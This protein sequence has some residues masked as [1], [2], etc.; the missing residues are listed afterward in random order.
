M[1]SKLK[2]IGYRGHAK[3]KDSLLQSWR[4][5]PVGPQIHLQL[6]HESIGAGIG[7]IKAKA[8]DALPP[9]PIRPIPIQV[10]VQAM[11]RRKA[12]IIALGQ[13]YIIK[14]ISSPLGGIANRSELRPIAFDHDR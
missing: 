10:Q 6:G 4:Q 7:V 5:F 14:Y 12:V 9:L 3:E 2:G 11:V 1:R 8:P 13:A